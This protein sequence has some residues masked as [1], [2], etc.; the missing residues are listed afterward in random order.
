MTFAQKVLIMAAL[1][2]KVKELCKEDGRGRTGFYTSVYH[3]GIHE[4]TFLTGDVVSREASKKC[5][6]H[7]QEKSARLVANR[8]THSAFQTRNEKK[9]SYGGGVQLVEWAISASGLSPLG[10][11]NASLIGLQALYGRPLPAEFLDLVVQC[12][13]NPYRGVFW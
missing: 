13:N 5:I 11:E 9:G 8:H 6:F 4:M 10:E 2:G 3:H 7:A 1:E 12:S